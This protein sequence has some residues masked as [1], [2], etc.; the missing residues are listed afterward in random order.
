[1]NAHSTRSPSG[2]SLAET[3]VVIGILSLVGLALSTMIVFFYRSNA[4]LLEQTSAVDSVRRGLT[5][6]FES[7]REATYGEDGSYPIASAATSSVVIYSDIDSDFSVERI[8][9]WLYNG[10]FYQVTTNAGGNPPTYAGQPPATTTI[11]TYVRNSNTTP[12]FRYFD[13]NGVELTG[14]AVDLSEVASIRTRLD[15]DL[16]P[17]RLPNV[18]TLEETATLRN[19]R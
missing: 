19:L 7:L 11:A 18:V 16:N 13:A 1:M 17:L 10:T 6:T 15:V 12:I 2:F 5:R 8:R 9:F 14:A 4:F 3:M